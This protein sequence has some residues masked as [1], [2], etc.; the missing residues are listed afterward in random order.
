MVRARRAIFRA[1]VYKVSEVEKTN[2]QACE[3]PK[4]GKM[5]AGKAGP[6]RKSWQAWWQTKE[7]TRTTVGIR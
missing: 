1:P 7:R 2:E 3:K 5:L 4:R 6:R